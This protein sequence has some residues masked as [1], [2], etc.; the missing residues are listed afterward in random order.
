MNFGRHHKGHHAHGSPHNRRS[1][2]FARLVLVLITLAAAWLA[3]LIWFVGQIPRAEPQPQSSTDAVVVLTGG[4]RRLEAGLDL[5][6]HGWAG[7]L[8]VSGVYER[9][10]VRTLLDVFQRQLPQL[11]CCIELGY[12]ANDT[13]GNAIETARWVERSGVSSFRLVTSNYHMPRAL[14]EFGHYFPEFEIVPHPV[15]PETHEVGE[16][17]RSLATFKLI[18]WEYSKYLL[19]HVTSWIGFEPVLG[20]AQNTEADQ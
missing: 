1:R 4:S 9:V 2:L 8:Y 15:L 7:S 14:F 18:G 11:A 12:A 13:R 10:D 17:W 20:G 6:G 5:L 16:W 3:G 19:A